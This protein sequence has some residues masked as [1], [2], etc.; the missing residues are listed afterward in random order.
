MNSNP[1][2][3][4]NGNPDRVIV[5]DAPDPTQERRDIG[6]TM[7]WLALFPCLGGF[8]GFAGYIASAMILESTVIPNVDPPKYTYGQQ[9]GLISTPLSTVIGFIAGIGVAL[10]IKR[11]RILSTLMMLC[12]SALGSYLTYGM[13][14][15]DGI[16]ECTSAIVLYYPIFGLCGIV[17]ALGIVFATIT[18]ILNPKRRITNG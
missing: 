3:S 11:L 9:F 13:W 17:A 15:N 2:I 5:H 18:L 4:P 12:V 10:F 14:Y 6:T 1:Y 16:G 7:A 8:I